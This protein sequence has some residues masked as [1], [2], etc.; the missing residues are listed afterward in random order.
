MSNLAAL[1]EI[2]HDPS[3]MKYWKYQNKLRLHAEMLY[4]QILQGTAA[5]M[6]YILWCPRNAG[7]I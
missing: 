7:D 3:Y 1:F 2:T 5:L 6:L 4:H